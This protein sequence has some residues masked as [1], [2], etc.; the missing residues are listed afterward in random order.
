DTE[1]EYD[2]RLIFFI[3]KIYLRNVLN[4]EINKQSDETQYIFNVLNRAFE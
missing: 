2:L 1:D 4:L 3:K